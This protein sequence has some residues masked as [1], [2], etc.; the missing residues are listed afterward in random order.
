MLRSWC[1]GRIFF[2]AGNYR[3]R[4][5]FVLAHMTKPVTVFLYHLLMFHGKL[6]R[7]IAPELFGTFCY[8][9]LCCSKDVSCDS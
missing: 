8:E 3:A 5:L 4:V 6:T 7:R 9:A 2:T 1:V